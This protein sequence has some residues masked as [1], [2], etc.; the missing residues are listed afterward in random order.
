M[1][2][3]GGETLLQQEE[4]DY[5]QSGEQQQKGDLGNRKM[6]ATEIGANRNKK[7]HKKKTQEEDGRRSTRSRGCWR[8][9]EEA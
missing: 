1:T 3:R 5:H 7:E 6:E 8:P 4:E 2:K 9:E